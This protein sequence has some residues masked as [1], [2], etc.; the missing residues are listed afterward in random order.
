MDHTISI[1]IAEHGRRSQNGDRLLGALSELRPNADPVIDQNIE[2]GAITAAFQVAANDMGAAVK[3]G[4]EVITE[5]AARAGLHPLHV[6]SVTGSDSSPPVE[7]FAT[8]PVDA[9]G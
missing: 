6:V 2:T 3:D 7:P 8:A 9:R 5:A 4:L 1:T